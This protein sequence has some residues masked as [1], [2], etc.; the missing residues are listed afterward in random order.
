MIV[1]LGMVVLASTSI[2]RLFTEINFRS[3]V[4]LTTIKQLHIDL[5]IISKHS[6]F[7]LSGFQEQKSLSSANAQEM[8]RKQVS[9]QRA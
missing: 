1:V 3:L 5:Q 9:F 7:V 6:T 2:I 8:R 4:T